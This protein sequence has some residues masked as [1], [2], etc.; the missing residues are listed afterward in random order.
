M[1]IEAAKA[2]AD[3]IRTSL[4]PRGMDKMVAQADGEVII[5]NDGATILNKMKVEQPAAKMLVDLAKSQASRLPPFPPSSGPHSCTCRLGPSAPAAP[6]LLHSAPA[7]PALALAA[8]FGHVRAT[9]RDQPSRGP[10]PAGRGGGRRHHLCDRA[11]RRAAEEEPGDAG[12]GGAPHRHLRRLW[13]GGR[14]GGGG[15][16][17]GRLPASPGL[18]PA[19]GS[20]QGLAACILPSPCPRRRPPPHPCVQILTA[21]AI[22]VSIDDRQQLIKAANTSLSSKIVGQNSGL[23]S[24]MAVDC[25]LKILDPQRPDLLDLQDVKVGAGGGVVWGCALPPCRAALCCAAVCSW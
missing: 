7:I 18:Q 21:S 2:V 13:Q 14:Q 11:V 10:P 23:L 16:R 12:E 3:A 20:E 5:T 15:A 9:N 1:N 22:P 25:L 19:T 17:P 8:R 6:Q 4:G 24:P